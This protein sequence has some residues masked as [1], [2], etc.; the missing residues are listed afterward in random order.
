MI[1]RRLALGLAAALP[2]VWGLSGCGKGGG[3]QP[4]MKPATPPVVKEDTGG[5]KAPAGDKAKPAGDKTEAAAGAEEGWGTITGQIIFEGNV[6][7]PTILVKQGDQNAKN[8][9]VCAVKDVVSEDLV[10]DKETK[11]LKWAVVSIGGKLKIHPD[12]AK[13]E[14]TAEMGQE[15][16]HFIPHVLAM[17]QGQKFIVSSND[18]VGHNSNCAGI[19]NATF[20]PLIPA[21]PPGGKTTL[22]GPDLVAD[23]LKVNCN[24]HP[25]MSAY[26]IV[27]DHPYFAVT[28]DKGN[29]KIENVPA[30]A[31]KLVIWQDKGF[32]EG[33]AKGNDITVKAGETTDLGKITYTPKN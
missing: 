1:S 8:A 2:L 5:T 23:R 27:F 12:L 6:P 24:I 3:S 32:N 9:E 25:W 17:R 14:G 15:H 19:K 21:A 26:I 4:V 10:V 29:F 28:D 33:S 20:N 16:C 22:D 11:G 30:G 31:Q 13:A 7:E 18:A